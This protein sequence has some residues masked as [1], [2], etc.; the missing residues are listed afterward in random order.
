MSAILQAE[1]YEDACRL[2]A[3]QDKGD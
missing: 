3:P 2:A 1:H